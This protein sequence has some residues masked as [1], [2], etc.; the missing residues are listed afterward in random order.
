MTT[1]ESGWLEVSLVVN[2]ELA[3]AVADVL[4]RFAPNGVVI[5]STAITSAPHEMG[6]PTGPLRVCAYLPIDDQI[7]DTRQRLIE[8]LWYLGRIQE[9]PEATFKT[10][11]NQNWME[12]WKQ[13]YKPV[14]VGQKLVI[15][16]TWADNPAAERIPI[17]IEPGMAFGTGTHP[18][19]QLSLQMLEE[20][21]QPGIEILDIGCG[22]GI[23]SIAAVRLGAKAA[24]GVDV[25]TE[26]IQSANENATLNEVAAGRVQFKIGSVAAVQA[27]ELPI[28]QAPVVIAN[29][30]AHIL[31]RLLDDGMADLVA[32]GGVLLLSG[33]LDEIEPDMLATLAKHNLVVV[34]RSQI[35]DWLG[36]V[37]RSEQ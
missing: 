27:G 8:S 17:R 3:E 21:V 19:T 26:S 4:A 16:P 22:S 33:I 35:E 29:I 9:L 20:H 31:I 23:L 28:R 18:T 5:E 14:L 2:G 11:H 7:E 25:E 36:L 12:A 37:V 15:L 1:P 30:L 6:E 13:H 10:I 24:Y 34:E 32:P